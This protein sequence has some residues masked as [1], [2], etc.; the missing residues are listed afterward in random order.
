MTPEPASAAL[1]LRVN[2]LFHDLEGADYANVHP[3]IFK[4]EARRWEALLTKHMKS[5]TPPPD[6]LRRCW[7]RNRVRI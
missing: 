2:E 1:V 7:M 3:E 4:A 6:L 5:M